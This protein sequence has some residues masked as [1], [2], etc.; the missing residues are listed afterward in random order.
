VPGKILKKCELLKGHM[1]MDK[2]EKMKEGM[3]K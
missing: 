1:M 2:G 3:M